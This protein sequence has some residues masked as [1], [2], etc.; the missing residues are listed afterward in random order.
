MS[1]IRSVQI[2][3]EKVLALHEYDVGWWTCDCHDHSSTQISFTLLVGSAL[4]DEAD[5]ILKDVY[6][7]LTPKEALALGSALSAA[8]NHSP[9]FQILGC[10]TEE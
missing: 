8:A 2:D 1:E 6:L 4:S 7:A 3:G 10:G 9:G 5:P